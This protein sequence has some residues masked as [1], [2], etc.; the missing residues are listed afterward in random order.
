MD[1]ILQ[2][3]TDAYDMQIPYLSVARSIIRLTITMV[4]TINASFDTT[5]A[6]IVRTPTD[7]MANTIQPTALNARNSGMYICKAFR[8]LWP[9]IPPPKPPRRAARKH[10]CRWNY[11]HYI[12]IILHYT[13]FYTNTG[14]RSI[15]IT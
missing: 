3:I 14:G 5:N 6:F 11:I 1:G 13:T 15:V 4:V 2:L 9:P 8:S 10:L 7:L 12:I